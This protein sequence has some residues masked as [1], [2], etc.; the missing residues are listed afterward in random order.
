MAELENKQRMFIND[1]FLTVKKIGEGG[2]GIVWKAYDFS[3]RNFVAIKQLLKEYTEPKFIEMFYKEALIAKN[4]IH[5]N[6]VRVQ[7]FWKGTDGSYYVVMD[8][9]SGDDL[10]N[11]IKK[12]NSFNIKLPWELSALIAENILKAIDYVSRLAKDPITGR[13][14]GLVYR[15]LSPGNVLISFEGN[16]KL[17]DFGIAKTADEISCGL[18]RRIVTGKYGYMSPEQIECK[19]DLDHRSDIFSVGVVLYEMLSGKPLFSGTNDEIRKQVLESRFD[20][21]LLFDASIPEDLVDI[22]VR[23]LE[24]NKEDRY[25]KAIE[26]YRD[27][28]R[29][30]KLKETEDLTLELSSFIAKIMTEEFN[31]EKESIKFVKQLNVQDIKSQPDIHNVYCKD[32]IM[33]ETHK[34]KEEKPAETAT[35]EPSKEATREERELKPIE[36]EEPPEARVEEKG[37]T[38]FEEV[39]DWFINKFIAYKKMLLRSVLAFFVFLMI[40]GVLDSVFQVSPFGKYVYSFL[41]PP[42]VV[43]TT[44]PSGA[45]VT[46]K[47]R[48]GRIIIADKDSTLPIQLRKILPRTYVL[49]AIKKGF[50]P[51][52]R[53]VK[54]EEQTKGVKK[55]KLQR[56][57][58]LFDFMLRV[59]ADVEGASVYIDGNKVGVSTWT[60]T[61]ATGEHTVKLT[62]PGFEDLGSVAKEAREGQASL[63]FTKGNISE[64]FSNVD[65]KYW[66]YDMLTEN[67]NTIFTLTGVMVKKV[68]VNSVPERMVLHIQKESQDRGKTPLA[69]SLKS[70]E[71]LLRLMDP[72]GRYAETTATLVVGKGSQDSI[73]IPLKKWVTLKV[74][75]KGFAQEPLTVTVLIKGNGV[76]LT[77]RVSTSRPLR[78]ALFPGLY[79]FVFQG[80]KE[81]EP[82]SSGSVNISE[83]SVIVGEMRYKKVPIK[84]FVRDIKSKNPISDASVWTSD[85]LLGKTGTEGFW[86]GL[87][88]YGTT[89]LGIVAKGYIGKTV[90]EDLRPSEKRQISVDL[91]PE[92]TVPVTAVQE[93]NKMAELKN[94]LENVT[95]TVGT[96]VGITTG[97][98]VSEALGNNVVGVVTKS[99][100][101]A[102][103]VPHMIT[104][105][106]QNCGTVYH[107]SS[108]KK[109]RF[110]T[111]CG[112]PLHY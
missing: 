41:Y 94:S 44:V 43:I 99:T 58:L 86:A 37:K 68:T 71:Y 28:R 36:P 8:Y 60:G 56:L 48:E 39:G 24:K 14:Y 72:E 3:L 26:M 5:D 78:V 80:N 105:A 10:E 49:S 50:K 16:V 74:R 90:T 89:T 84:I 63:D 32:F 7:H 19:N 110:C 73:N 45:L 33:G 82:Y 38:V 96:A 83:K 93:P 95:A 46:L 18:N 1:Q 75:T 107:V 101:T 92:E 104:V 35:A 25:E 111:N 87:V 61:I 23:A 13:P 29:L 88:E 69:V 70:G 66:K 112:K 47:T 106:C 4:I 76:D 91:A 52:A 62:A 57:E 11:L 20:P 12:C 65:T 98:G 81:Y 42:D 51:A 30:L 9:V 103:N 6:I 67:D 79:K 15:D 34:E 55:N 85:R 64:I 40:F 31:S 108:D 97:K 77:E 100:E 17:S 59:S 109:L 27:M 2:F 21:R 22:V 54:I 53:V 102:R